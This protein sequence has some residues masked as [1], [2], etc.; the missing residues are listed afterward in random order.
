MVYLFLEHFEIVNLDYNISILIIINTSIIAIP[1]FTELLIFHIF[2]I[3]TY[4]THF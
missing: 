1:I 3:S 2:F 4:P